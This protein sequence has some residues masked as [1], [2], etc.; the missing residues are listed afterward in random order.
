MLI[1]SHYDVFRKKDVL[2]NKKNWS[3]IFN[4]GPPCQARQAKKQVAL[5]KSLRLQSWGGPAAAAEAV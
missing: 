3:E 1:T 2:E 4:L 5:E